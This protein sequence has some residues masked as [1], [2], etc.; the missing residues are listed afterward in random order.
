MAK[1]VGR[2][3][4]VCSQARICTC[5]ILYSG[6]NASGIVVPAS[7]SIVAAPNR[8]P[9]YSAMQLQICCHF[10][11]LFMQT[12]VFACIPKVVLDLYLEGK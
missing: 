5:P 10:N 4:L 9:V 2:W 6:N 3:K 11:D 8:L 7:N 1:N 12:C